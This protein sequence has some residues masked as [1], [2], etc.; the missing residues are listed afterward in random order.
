MT[1][2]PN[3]QLLP[4]DLPTPI[5]DGAANHLKGMRLPHLSLP[6]TSGTRVDLSALKRRTIV[7]AYP[8]TGVPGVPLPNGWDAIPGARGCTV[9]CL[10]FK[11]HRAEI[12]ELGADVFGL[13]TQDTA[14]RRK[15]RS[16]FICRS[17]C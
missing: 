2:Q 12:G 4:A 7:Y 5:D 13:S 17:K 10:S 3:F 14:Y 8:M 9:E 11:D 15:W 6:S 16:G 1:S